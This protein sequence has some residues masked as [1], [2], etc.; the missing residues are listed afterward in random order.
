MT[1]KLLFLLIAVAI[2]TPA[3]AQEPVMVSRNQQALLGSDDPQLAANKKLVYDFWRV[4]LDARDMDRAPEFVSDAY[5]QHNPGV[6]S[7]R[8]PFVRIMSGAPRNELEETIPDL[9]TIF[10]ED[11][12]V[13]MAFRREFDNPR[14]PGE[15]YTTTW[16]EMFR[17]RNNLVDEHWD[18][19]QIN[20][21]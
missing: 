13:I 9:V 20:P 6:A 7:G 10:A 12:M 21:R 5:I 19:G 2:V 11:D 1:K 18:Y 8:E 15:T 16:F 3:L 17:V 4:I 14:S